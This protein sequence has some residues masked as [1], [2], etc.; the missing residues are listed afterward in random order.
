MSRLGHARV[1]VDHFHAVRLA[2]T[3]VGQVRRRT[4]QATLGHRGRKLNPLLRHP[5]AAADLAR[6]AHPAWTSRATGRAGGGRSFRCRRG[7]AEKRATARR[8]P[9][10]RPG[11]SPRRLW[12]ASPAGAM[13]SR[14]LSCPGW[15]A[16]C[17]LG[18]R[19]PG[20]PRQ[21]RLLQRT[22]PAVN[23]L[24]KKVKRIGHGFRSYPAATAIA[25]RRQVADSPHRKTARSVPTVRGIEP[26]KQEPARSSAKGGHLATVCDRPIPSRQTK[27]T[28][29]EKLRLGMARQRSYTRERH[30]SLLGIRVLGG[31]NTP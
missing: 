27:L 6:A 20:L 31:G 8:P 13:A 30:A 2:N 10:G 29:H 15:P 22:H 18:G 12:I 1:V 11:G 26:L 23:L 3:V 5:Q 16:P 9:S 4:Q 17:E 14:S 25:L 19:D 28:T 7:L 24:V 21:R